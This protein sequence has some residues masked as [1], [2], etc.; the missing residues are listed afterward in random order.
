MIWYGAKMCIKS[1]PGAYND[2]IAEQ[3]KS[4]IFDTL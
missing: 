3:N 4:A 1:H 2:A